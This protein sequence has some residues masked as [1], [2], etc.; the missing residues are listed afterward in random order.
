MDTTNTLLDTEIDEVEILEDEADDG[1]EVL[2][3]GDDN[4]SPGYDDHLSELLQQRIKHYVPRA[5]AYAS[6]ATDGYVEVFTERPELIND[7]F[8][9]DQVG[10]CLVAEELRAKANTLQGTLKSEFV[11]GNQLLELRYRYSDDS[12]N[13][14]F[15]YTIT[16]DGRWVKGF[17]NSALALLAFDVIV[18]HRADRFEEVLKRVI[19]LFHTRGVQLGEDRRE[20]CSEEFACEV[21]HEIT[22]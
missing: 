3:D 11:E 13:A 8:V 5:A 21:Y 15:V 20:Q 22:A 6:E 10:I 4:G 1:A 9:V 7:S 14:G 16:I 18:D 19:Y 17:R 2:T 12:E